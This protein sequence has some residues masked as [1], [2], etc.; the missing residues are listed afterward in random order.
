MQEINLMDFSLSGFKINNMIS[1]L[2]NLNFALV[3]LFDG[4]TSIEK[5][6]KIEDNTVYTESGVMYSYAHYAIF[7]SKESN[8]ENS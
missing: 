7:H 4:E 8:P 1:E 5:I 6:T 2:G 3:S